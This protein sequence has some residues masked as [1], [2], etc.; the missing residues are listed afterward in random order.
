MCWQ[1]LKKKK[2]KKNCVCGRW[3]GGGGG[4]GLAPWNINSMSLQISWDVTCPC[5]FQATSNVLWVS[6][7]TVKAKTMWFHQHQP[8]DQTTHQLIVV[9]V[10]YNSLTQ[11]GLLILI[12]V[13]IITQRITHKQLMHLKQTHS[14]FK[15]IQ[16]VVQWQSLSCPHA[17]LFMYIWLHIWRRG[18]NYSYTHGVRGVNSSAMPLHN[19]AEL[20]YRWFS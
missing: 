3:E 2:K 16:K 5:K 1:F 10:S 18:E 20:Y 13:S 9:G 19:V 15:A 12:F 14:N 4:G 6:R 7:A 11:R 17:R 8:A